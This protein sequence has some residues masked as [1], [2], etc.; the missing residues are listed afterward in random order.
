MPRACGMTCVKMVLDFYKKKTAP[1][2][3]MIAV[4][5]ADGGYGPSGWF[6]DYFV[7]LFK[8]Y[9]LDSYRKE[10]MSEDSVSGIQIAL[11]DENPVIVSIVKKVLEQEKFHMIVLTGYTTDK[12][13]NIKTFF[14]HDPEGVSEEQGAHRE[15][16]IATF[17]SGWRKM[18]IFIQ[19]HSDCN[20]SGA[21]FVAQ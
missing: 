9:G 3:K 14:Y 2:E 18:V 4:G 7:A 10:G 17:L 11:D 20:R 1:L 16:D 8:A 21:V 19:H 13:G 6:H 12:K 15:V 5:Q